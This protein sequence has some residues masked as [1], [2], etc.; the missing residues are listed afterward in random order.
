MR[1]KHAVAGG[2]WAGGLGAC[3]REIFDVLRLILLLFGT[4]SIFYHG[5]ASVNPPNPPS[6]RA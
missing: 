3:P 5:K 6:L 2:G 1:A 4:L